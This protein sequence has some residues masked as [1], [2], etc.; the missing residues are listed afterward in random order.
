MGETDGKM[1]SAAAG[2]DEIRDPGLGIED[3]AGEDAGSREA[4]LWQ[5][6]R[7]IAGLREDV[8]AI[9]RVGA[10]KATGLVRRNPWSAIVAALCAGIYLGRRGL[11]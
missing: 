11:R 8:A 2:P 5:L 3:S 9:T 6:R 10:T 4:K 7:D 1:K